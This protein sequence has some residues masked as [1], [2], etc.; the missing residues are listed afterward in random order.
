VE[1]SHRVGGHPLLSETLYRRG[2]TDPVTLDRYLNPEKYPLC[3]PFDLPD[4]DRAVDRIIAAI[5]NGE[6]IGVWGDF[7]VDGQ[8][9]TTLLVSGLRRLGA[10]VQYY[11]PVRARE[12]HGVALP[13]LERF[14]QSGVQLLLTC[15]TGITAHDAVAYASSHAIDTIITDH[16]TLP[17]DLPAAYAVV[18]PQRLPAAH[19]LSGLC[20]VGCA[21]E[22][23]SGLYERLGRSGEQECELDL[24]AL[25]TVADLARLTGDNRALVRRG[26][27]VLR[28]SIRPGLAAIYDLAE[29]NPDFL[30]EEHIG[31][32][33]APRLNA[34]GRLADSNPVVDFL[35]STNPQDVGLFANQLEG[36]NARRRLI[37]QEVFEAAQSQIQANPALLDT[38]VLVINHP[39]WPAGVIGI[40]ASRLVDFYHRPVIL[41]SSPPGEPARGSARSIEGVNITSAI[42]SAARLLLGYG[43]H[44]M[45]AGLSLPAERIPDFRRAVSH[46]VDAQTDG[47]PPISE[48]Q[49]DAWLALPDLNLDL[50]ASLERMAPFGPAN[51]AVTLA[52]RNLVLKSHSLIGKNG[53][54]LRLI[55]EDEQGTSAQV[56]WWQGAGFPLPEGKFDLA[57]RVR[58]SD[59]RG[60]RDVQM[61]YVDARPVDLPPI[62]LNSGAAIDTIDLRDCRSLRDEVIDLISPA[63]AIWAEG[64]E[65]SEIPGAD[66]YHLSPADAL[67]IYSIPPGQ[68]E[69]DAVLT[70]VHP[71][72]VILGNV[73]L[74]P[75]EL[76]PFLGRLG[77]LLKYALAARDG[78]VTLPE[79]AAATGQRIPTV[80]R[81]AAWFA[82]R[83]YLA[84]IDRQGDSLQLFAHGK[85]DSAEAAIIQKQIEILL[86]ETA[87]YRSFYLQ[88]DP[89][90]LLCS[91]F[92]KHTR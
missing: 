71:R 1:Y 26:L 68:P 41:I 33:I 74:A 24:L 36:L 38:S 76:Q 16:H 56:L 14:L 17:A 64:S 35:L 6:R 55:V 2:I 70:A 20:G 40:V 83:G 23:L 84:I 51:P 75:T 12:S 32:G 28:R 85:V 22:M 48:L 3:S 30:G 19:D 58:A 90:T 59:F 45:A 9:S 77:G 43:G 52:S 27:E 29:I 44:S 60:R 53:D 42:A 73:Q 7:D 63:T 37:S 10:T 11:I 13:A 46:A 86:K 50:V 67:V 4:L 81:G 82:A 15:D 57:F 5:H 89:L 72:R 91:T 78:R 79:L 21:Y 69:L 8:T 66:R 80:E 47:R 18:N 88:A 65:S 54:H 62:E 39:T 49:I 92:G 34:I 25:G 31:F 61:E 87:A